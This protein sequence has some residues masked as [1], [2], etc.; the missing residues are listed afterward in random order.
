MT[1]PRCWP[2]A[3]YRTTSGVA[4]IEFA[5]IAPVLLVLIVSG[6]EL[7]LAIRDS[8]RAQAAAAE[9]AYYAAANGF[10]A[11]K[12]ALAVVNGTGASGLRA[13]PA[14]SLF[15]GCPSAS[16]TAVAACD[17]TCD[18]GIAARKYVKVNASITRISVLDAHLGLPTEITRQSIARL[19]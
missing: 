4:A 2:V 6:I 16:G 1:F 13:S 9:G 15:C 14:P 8:L 7:G 10:D 19:P 12:I 18:D 17:A 5:I 11:D 3:L